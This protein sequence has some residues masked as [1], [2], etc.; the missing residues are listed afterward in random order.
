MPPILKVSYSREAALHAMIG[1]IKGVANAAVF[2]S[3][4]TGFLKRNVWKQYY[5]FADCR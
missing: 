2:F 5:I 4:P 3:L 1:I